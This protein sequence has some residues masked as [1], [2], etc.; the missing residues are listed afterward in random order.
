MI[1][2]TLVGT[3]DMDRAT[4]FYDALFGEIGATRLM[5]FPN[6]VVYGVAHDKPALGV[7]RPFDGKPATS[8]NGTMVGLVVDTREKVDRLYNKAIELGGQDE[9]PAGLRGEEGP[10]AFYVGYFRDLD[11]NKLCAFHAGPA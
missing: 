2:Y 10:Q 4:Q 7:C 3:N 11:G 5:E 6:A 8:G 9:G 1:G